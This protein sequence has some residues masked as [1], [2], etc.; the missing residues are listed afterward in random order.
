M[1]Y[2]QMFNGL[3]LMALSLHPRFAVHRFA[4]PAIA[5]GGF[6]FS[7]SIVALV[8]NKERYVEDRCSLHLPLFFL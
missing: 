8:L 2:Y 4:G 3:A 1:I 5:M 7:S 6:L